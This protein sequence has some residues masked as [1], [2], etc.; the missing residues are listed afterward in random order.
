MSAKKTQTK[1]TAVP[2][3]SESLQGAIDHYFSDD[4]TKKLNKG[5]LPGLTTVGCTASKVA[6]AFT[7]KLGSSVWNWSGKAR[8]LKAE[9]RAKAQGQPA[10]A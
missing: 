7:L 4:F 2:T 10:T 8:E 1:E 3:P 6:A 5:Q 9:A